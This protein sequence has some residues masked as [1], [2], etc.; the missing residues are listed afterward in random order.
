MNPH[1]KGFPQ[2]EEFSL[3]ILVAG[4]RCNV[5]GEYFERG[6]HQRENSHTLLIVSRRIQ[7][8]KRRILRSPMPNEHPAPPGPNVSS[9]V[10]SY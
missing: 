2:T 3:R 1:L 6:L 7:R 10:G 9:S 8:S 4:E 5:T